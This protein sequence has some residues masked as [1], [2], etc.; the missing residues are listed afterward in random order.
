MIILADPKSLFFYLAGPKINKKDAAAALNPGAGGGGAVLGWRVPCRSP[1][2]ASSWLNWGKCRFCLS[3]PQGNRSSWQDRPRARHQNVLPS[4]SRRTTFI[5]TAMTQGSRT[6]ERKPWDPRNHFCGL[7]ARKRG[8]TLLAYWCRVHPPGVASQTAQPALFRPSLASSRPCPQA[9]SPPSHFCQRPQGAPAGKIYLIGQE[10]PT[11]QITW[12][13][14]PSWTNFPLLTPEKHPNGGE[15]QLQV[16]RQASPAA[17]TSSDPAPHLR[18][19]L[20]CCDAPLRQLRIRA[21]E[22]PATSRPGASLIGWLEGACVQRPCGSAPVGDRPQ[23]TTTQSALRG[24][25]C[26][27]YLRGQA[28]SSLFL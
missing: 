13:G 1:H 27:W 3:V 24:A 10:Q 12:M 14:L 26:G 4:G 20:R 2:S 9:A 23:E 19:S 5:K 15:P 28:P 21:W 18:C 11:G 7:G 8:P 25:V 16:S 6:R 17:P 22:K